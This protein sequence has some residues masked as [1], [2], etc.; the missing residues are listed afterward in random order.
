MNLTTVESGTVTF[1][2]LWKARNDTDYVVYHNV[3]NVGENEYTLSGTDNLEGT[4]DSTL[5][6]ANLKKTFTG[7]N[8]S[9]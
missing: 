8:Y 4:T 6:L 2:A 7:F 9:A 3:K 1:T 5:T